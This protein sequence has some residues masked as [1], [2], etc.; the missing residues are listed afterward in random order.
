MP[1]P[2][3]FDPLDFLALAKELAE[4]GGEDRLRTAIGRAYYGL[5]LLAR[6]R[7]GAFPT[8]KEDSA[9]TLVINAVRKRRGFAVG[10]YLYRLKQLRITADY[11]L[12]SVDVALQ[13]W[14]QN[15][16]TAQAL[17]QRL[18]PELQAL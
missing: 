15:W 17:V 10:N 12:L 4:V 16:A 14:D 3:A 18:L 1:L 11:Q 2:D 13:D 6:E 8:R 9:H 7:T 5:F